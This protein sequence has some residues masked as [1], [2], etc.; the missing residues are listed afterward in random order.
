[1][2]CATHSRFNRFHGLFSTS[3]CTVCGDPDINAAGGKTR[4]TRLVFRWNP[5]SSLGAND[6]RNAGF[7]ATPS[8]NFSFDTMGAFV[9]VTIDA[10]PFATNT[11]FT[12]GDQTVTLHTSVVPSLCANDCV[13]GGVEEVPCVCVCVGGG[14]PA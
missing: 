13:G 1:M 2:S 14:V 9:E 12:V 5:I 7:A 3:Q 6:I 8:T 10:D 4:L 11:D